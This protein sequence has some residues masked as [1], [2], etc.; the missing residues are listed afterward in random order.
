MLK[1]Y[2]LKIITILCLLVCVGSGILLLN[3]WIQQ[4]KSKLLYETLADS[5]PGFSKNSLIM[6]NNR[7]VSDNSPILNKDMSV[8]YKKQKTKSYLNLYKKNNHFTGWIC[9]PNTVINYPFMQTTQKNKNYYINKDFNKTNSPYGTPY[10]DERCNLKGSK[11]AVILYGHHMKDGTM[12]AQLSKYK[13]YSFYETHP[14]IL[15]DYFIE[16]RL[17]EETYQIFSVILIKDIGDMEYPYY[18][19]VSISNKEFD[20]QYNSYIT[21][22]KGSALYDTRHTPKQ[23]SSLLLLS[24]CDYSGKDGRILVAAYKINS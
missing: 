22:L 11:R 6:S 16:G 5:V 17:I 15:L 1:K 7:I 3:E 19:I 18:D 20:K 23:N 21:A 24:T 12:F 10:I 8:E 2:L 9:I 13:D 14:T 4:Q